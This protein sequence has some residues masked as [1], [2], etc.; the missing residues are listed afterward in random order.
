MRPSH[1][2]TTVAACTVGLTAAVAL[3][4][5]TGRRLP[6]PTPTTTTTT[7]AVGTATATPTAVPPVAPLPG[8]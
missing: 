3:H 8:R 1:L 6:A 4:R 2:V 7:T 5:R